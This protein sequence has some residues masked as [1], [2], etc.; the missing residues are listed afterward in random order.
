MTGKG[1]YFISLFIYFKGKSGK[2]SNLTY[3]FFFFFGGDNVKHQKE[4]F[5]VRKFRKKKGFTV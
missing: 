4:K 1:S 2:R 5:K 3:S